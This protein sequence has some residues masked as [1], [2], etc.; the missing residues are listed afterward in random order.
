MLKR[1]G[2]VAFNWFAAS[3]AYYGLSL[4][5]GNLVGDLY[6]NYVVTAAVELP[7]CVFT[8]VTLDRLGRKGPHVFS[9][10]L[11]GIAC[12]TN[13][14]IVLY[15]D[16][17]H[18]WITVALSTV[19]KFG[20][21]AAFT[22]IYIFASELFPTTTRNGIMGLCSVGGRVGS[23]VSPYIA[24]LGDLIVGI[25]GVVLPMTIFGVIALV[26]GVLAIFLPE[27]MG[28]AL[29]DTIEQALE[30][31]KRKRKQLGTDESKIIMD[32]DT[33]IDSCRIYETFGEK[34]P[35]SDQV[36]LPSYQVQPDR[37][38]EKNIESTRI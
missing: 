35:A 37:I 3:T 11:C 2:I 24:S 21:T 23:M 38:D 19:G 18:H 16:K 15:V 6:V 4:N 25:Y 28:E 9:M 34:K 30:L 13:I 12:L 31:G 10:F 33:F 14:F 5:S 1:I 27:T 7:A 36:T 29:P 8:Y 17:E 32:N 26:A 20:S 22:T